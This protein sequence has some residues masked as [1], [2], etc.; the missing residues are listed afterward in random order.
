V[1]V[2]GSAIVAKPGLQ[3]KG[4]PDPSRSVPGRDAYLATGTVRVADGS[5][6]IVVSVHSRIGK[7]AAED[8]VGLDPEVIRRP[9]EK[10]PHQDDIDY[11]LIRE[12]VRDG[13][14]LVSGD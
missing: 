7:T 1:I 4:L 8:L 6:L 2:W 10:A 13:R 3:L 11:A 9:Q 14:F 12:R 5:E